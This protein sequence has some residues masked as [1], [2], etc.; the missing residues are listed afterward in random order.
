MN[1]VSIPVP[2]ELDP[3]IKSV[4]NRDPSK[5]EEWL[6]AGFD[7]QFSELYQEWQSL[8]ISMGR[9]AERMGIS[10]WELN[11]LLSRRGLRCTNLP[12]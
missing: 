4:L 6:R 2:A 3:V 7:A 9:F 8:R 12:G 5:G 11:D 1:S 10:V